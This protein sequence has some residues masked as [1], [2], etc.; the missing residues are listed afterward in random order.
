MVEGDRLQGKAWM[1][2][3]N[4]NMSIGHC[5]PEKACEVGFEQRHERKIFKFGSK[6]LPNAEASAVA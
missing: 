2:F 4:R 1:K 5:T 6:K 3:E